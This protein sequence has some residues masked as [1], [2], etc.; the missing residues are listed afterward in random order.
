MS[1]WDVK[2]LSLFLKIKPSTL[3]SWVAQAKI[4]HVRVNGLI[5]F[6]RKAIDRWL[7]S[8]Q[9]EKPKTPQKAPGGKSPGNI[10]TLIARAKR[11]VYNTPQGE[12][13]PIS[14]AR[15]GGK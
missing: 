9:Q 13:R 4:P 5:R 14:S 10:D 6:D 3:Y 7:E 8:F 12:T 15:K 11:E 2:E 1:L